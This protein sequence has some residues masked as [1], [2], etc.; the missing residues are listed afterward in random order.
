MLLSE[1]SDSRKLSCAAAATGTELRSEATTRSRHAAQTWCTLGVW[2]RL[3]ERHFGLDHQQRHGAPSDRRS[4][5]VQRLHTGPWQLVGRAHHT[6]LNE[7]GAH[8]EPG[9]CCC[10]PEET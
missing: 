7:H 2:W 8:R 9:L 3:P 10:H 6:Y 5:A 1:A 4:W